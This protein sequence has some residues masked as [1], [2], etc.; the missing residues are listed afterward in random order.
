MTPARNSCHKKEKLGVLVPEGT[1]AALSFCVV[2]NDPVIADLTRQLLEA[3]GHRV[4]VFISSVEALKAIPE[5]KPDVVISD[6]MMPEMDGFTLCEKLRSLP[7][8]F[9][10]KLVILSA[11]AYDF[12]RERARSLGALGFIPKPLNPEIFVNQV[13]ACISEQFTVRYWGVRDTLPVPGQKSL[14]YGGNTSCIS[15]EFPRQ[16]NFVFDAGSGIKELSDHIMARRGGKW[17]AKM[18]ISHPHWDHINA[19]PYFVPMYI[20]GNEFEIIGGRHGD[21]TMRELVSA[22]MDDVYFPIIL[23]EMG[24]RIYFREIGAQSTTF[25]KVEVQSLMLSHPGLCL[26][27]RVN[28]NGKSFCYITDNEIYPEDTPQHNASYENELADFMRGADVALMDT[29]Y[30]D[31]EYRRKINWGHSAVSEVMRIA[32][33]AEVKE[34]QLFHHD[35]DQSDDD[36]DRKLNVAQ[37]KLA[38]LGSKTIC[39]A[40]QEGTSRQL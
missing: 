20:P 22:Q 25:G 18:F 40:P 13:M 33:A 17:S 21:K 36:I 23:K 11:K 29:C 16:L 19:I 30:F 26:G 8:L 32:H 1:K 39:S 14:R 31:D 35:P 34:V 12:D 5:H 28:F 3:A 24:A 9:D 15:M 6:I 2:E 10:T 38:K 7:E 27:Y 4:R 37:E